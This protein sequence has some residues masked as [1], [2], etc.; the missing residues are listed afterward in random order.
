MAPDDDLRGASYRFGVFEVDSR[1]GELRKHGRPLK[2][3]GR[4]F[5]ILVL[6][7]G[8]RGDVISRDEL[9]QRL[10][11]ADTFV[12]FDHGLNSAVNRLRETLGDSAGSPRFIE[13]L[14][15]HGYRCIAPIEVID[16]RQP[17][18]V[19]PAAPASMVPAEPIPVRDVPRPAPVSLPSRLV[20]PLAAGALALTVVV[21]AAYLKVSHPTPAPHSAKMTLAVLP[22]ENLSSDAD[23]DFFSDGFT[24]EMIAELGKLDP[25]HLGVIARTTTRL[26]KDARKG[27]GQIR[28]ELGVDYVLEGSIRRANDRMRITA[29]LIQTGDMTHLWAESYDRD[30]SDVLTIQ[31]EVAMKIARS[32]T[33]ALHRPE[34]K[35]TNATASSA[36]YD[37]YL[38]G[39]FFRDQATEGSTRKAIE[40]FQRAVAA[41][42]KYA[43][44][45]AGMADAYWLLGAPG[46]EVEQPA[47][48][49]QKAQ[50][51]AEQALALDPLLAD[52]HAVLA[53]IRLSYRWDREG[54][55]QEIREAI[56]LNPSYAQAHQYYSTT[57]TS[58]GRFGEAI[59]EA[60]R[61][62]D[63]DLLSAPASTT[64][65]IRYYYAGRMPDAIAQ[66]SKTLE[67]SPEF[68]IA[69]WGLAQAYRASGGTARE[70]DELQRA[71][72][73][74]GNSAYMRAHLAYGLAASGERE[75]AMA[76]QRELETEGR[77][78]YTSPYHLAL[79][80][81]G[82]G[83]RDAMMRALE[84]AFADR[85]GWMVFLPVEPEFE[86]V[87]QTPEFQRLLARVQPMR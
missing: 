67:T 13:T 21:A 7:L 43:R 48:L 68:A 31:T 29:Q 66:F 24:E 62:L 3:R 59:A 83:D 22:F 55:E 86:R 82:I 44:A 79:I 64:L 11:P 27:I 30:V 2:L 39:R 6:L 57:L 33:L 45:Y 61:A 72:D 1:T 17:A 77:E 87:R 12:D 76:I 5:D 34:A 28:Q 18:T 36:A 25:D 65:G 73:L 71:V 52:A 16:Q 20:L 53:M 84:R 10:W 37:L 56:R 78:R 9:R 40:Y 4:P 63:L 81:A 14:P 8:R 47:A 69:H 80:A 26:Y 15:K 38:R 35:P 49:L 58:M 74:S 32:L 23:Q 46:W 60:K 85:S 51:S 50:A 70:L 19:A 54:S 41:D 75:R 42:A